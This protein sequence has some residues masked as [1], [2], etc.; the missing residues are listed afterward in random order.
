MFPLSNFLSIATT[1]PLVYKFL[2]AHAIFTAEPNLSP[3]L[4]NPIVQVPVPFEIVLNK[5]CLIVL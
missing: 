2:L 4:L 5:I 3:L 1:L